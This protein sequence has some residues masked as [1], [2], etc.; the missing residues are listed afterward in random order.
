MVQL[1]DEAKFN[2][3][4]K[5]LVAEIDKYLKDTDKYPY[6]WQINAALLLCKPGS[7]LQIPTGYGKSHVICLAAFH[8]LNW[9]K[10]TKVALYFPNETIMRWDLELFGRMLRQFKDRFKCHAK[11]MKGF[12]AF[13]VEEF[14][15]A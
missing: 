8:I 13:A 2:E 15:P 10:D 3:E 4:K 6:D 14:D 11:K 9:Q 5:F 12:T 7:I 1:K